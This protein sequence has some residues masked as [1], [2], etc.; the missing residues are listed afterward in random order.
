MSGA[1]RA[2]GS[3]R[4]LIDELFGP[5]GV[6]RI[7]AL[8]SPRT[9]PPG[10]L[11]ERLGM[12]REAEL[13]EHSQIGGRWAIELVYGLLGHEWT[14]EP[15]GLSQIDLVTGDASSSSSSL[16]PKGVQKA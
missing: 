14:I 11:M 2:V 10:Q 7:V 16:F 1:L 4:A 13:R 12:K 8:C 15:L 9:R 5:S 3:E 6:R